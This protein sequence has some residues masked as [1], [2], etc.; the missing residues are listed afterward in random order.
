[1]AVP[2]KK[3]SKSRTRRR[4]AQHKVAKPHYIIDPETIFGT[5]ARAFGNFKFMTSTNTNKAI[6]YNND[7]KID[8]KYE[9]G[10][11]SWDRIYRA[12]R[13]IIR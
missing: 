13:K 9:N 4:K 10:Y 12:L 3:M 11:I 2:K 5:W 1:M 7:K 8:I 6:D